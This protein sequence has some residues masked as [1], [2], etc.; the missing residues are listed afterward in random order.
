MEPIELTGDSR[1]SNK[2]Y[3]N[4]NKFKNVVY[5]DIAEYYEKDGKLLRGKK[6]ITLN[7]KEFEDL[8]ECSK[9]ILEEFD[10]IKN[11]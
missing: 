3:I 7:R 4:V 9:T 5:I 8:I 11:S 2:R 10:N 1:K 6:G